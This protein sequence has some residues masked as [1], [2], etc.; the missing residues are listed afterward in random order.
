MKADHAVRREE[1]IRRWNELGGD[2]ESPD[3]YEL[4]EFGE[5]IMR[6]RPTNRYQVIAQTVAGAIT[7]AARASGLRRDIRL[8]RP[9][10]PRP[11]CRVDEAGMLGRVRHA[12]AATISAV[13]VRR[14]AF[15][16][17]PSELF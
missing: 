3:Y 7:G 2:P 17:L 9:R 15:A 8:H 16:R 12:D 14:G 13:P 11:G 1:L 4:N 10:Y 5:V 6:P